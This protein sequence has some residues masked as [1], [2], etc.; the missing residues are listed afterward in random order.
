MQILASELAPEG[1]GRIVVYGPS[2]MKGYH[3]RPEENQAIFTED[4]GLRTG[5]MGRLDEEGYIWITG[6]SRSQYKLE[7]G[8]FVVPVPLRSALSSACISIKSWSMGAIV[9]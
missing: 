8:K 9:L 1:Q 3:N 2:V 6:A 4:G 7:T 5:D